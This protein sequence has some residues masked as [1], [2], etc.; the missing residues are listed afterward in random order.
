MAKIVFFSDFHAHIFEDFAKPDSEFVNDRFRAQIETLQRVF[1]IA[2]EQEAVLIF[3]G[4]LFHKRAKIDD[5]VFNKVYEVFAKNQD[6]HTVLVRG[7]HDSRTNAT[8][9]EHWL[10]SFQ[11]L[12]HVRVAAEP[13][14]VYVCD[15][16]DKFSTYN[17]F[18]IA[19]IPYSDDVALLKQKITE[20]SK[21]A[22][23]ETE[24]PTI[25]VAHIGVDGSEV[26]KHSHRLEGAFELGDLYPDVFQHV[27][28]GHYHKR[29][30][31]ADNVFY[32]GN[33][34]QASFSDEGQDKG[35]F[36]IDTDTEQPAQF[37]PIP[38]KQFVTLTEINENTQ[39]YVDNN[40]VRFILPQNQAQEVEIFKNESDNIRVEV[41][42]EY[43]SETRIAID[44][45][46]NEAQIVEAY[47]KEFYPGA[48]D[49][50]LDILKEAMG[51]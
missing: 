24:I 12:P 23:R 37:I 8:H 51:Q 11:Y 14:M 29:Q 43:K 36:V 32:A 42:R 3:G 45:E 17:E 21:D 10:E 28:L 20:F 46:S 41:Q 50:A 19:A 22:K 7:N 27:C 34:I 40:Y 16:N 9:T 26:G 25:L 49:L 13:E 35:V 39:D 44:M 5:I 18:K 15:D 38:N 31:L 30:F 1:Q 47:T 4:D 48:T 2:R 33:T 6:I